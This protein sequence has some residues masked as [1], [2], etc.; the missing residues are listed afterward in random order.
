M[1]ILSVHNSADIYGASRCL[2]RVMRLFV[3]DGH[4]VHVVLPS[5]GPLQA[6]LVESGIRV[7]IMPHL[8]IIDRSQLSSPA[9]WLAFPFR[10]ASSTFELIALILRYRVDAVHTNTAVLPTAPLAARLT[11]RRSLWHIR[12]FFSE[13]PSVWRFFQHYMYL[14]STR[15][16][17]ISRAVEEQFKPGLRSRCTIVYDGLETDAADCDLE[18]VQALRAL[19]GNPT[20]L[21]AVVGRIKWVRKG[22][23]VLIKAAALLA[24]RFPEV[25]YLVVGSVYPGNEDHLVRLKALVHA[26]GLDERVIFAGEMEDTRNVYAA[27][28]ITV[29]PSIQPEPFGLV[30]MESMA[31]G[32]PVIGSRCGGIPEQIVEGVTGLLFEPGDEAEL[33]RALAS[34]LGD[35]ERRRK[36]GSAGQERFRERF[37]IETTYARMAE[38]FG[39]R[40]EAARAGRLR[41]ETF[42]VR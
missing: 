25:K 27:A 41:R 38:C 28:D 39:G 20:K 19:A 42:Q 40:A 5:P 33:A 12:E 35:E 6:L 11:G 31:M 17:T 21:V 7:H 13:F 8:A 16:L 18:K 29:A 32:T 22:Q 9:G 4:E 30:V 1:V 37:G 15:I 3:Q 10:F 24:D 23:E 14:L 34:L 2:L 36:M 26:S